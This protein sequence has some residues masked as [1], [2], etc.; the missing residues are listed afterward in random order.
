MPETAVPAATTPI[1]CPPRPDGRPALPENLAY[2]LTLPAAL[3][4][5]ALA[6]AATRAFLEAHH[7]HDILDAALQAVGELTAT[8]C[9]F[10]PEANVYV[11]LRYRDNA[12]RVTVY[13]GHPLHINRHLAAA[14][15]TRRRTAL[16]LLARLA[17]ECGGGW[18]YGPAR[19]PGGGTRTWVVLPRE[20]AVAYGR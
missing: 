12:L 14:C 9:Q 5:P 1:A 6:R 19:E 18:G 20:G 3:T 16:R 4:S 7:L 15:D 17:R 8:A 11:S 13:D 10:A 2:S